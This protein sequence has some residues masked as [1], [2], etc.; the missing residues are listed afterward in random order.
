MTAT[1]RRFLAL[2]PLAA[3]LSFVACVSPDAPPHGAEGEVSRELRAPL[4]RCWRETVAAIHELGVPVPQDQRPDVHRGE[5]RTEEV[6]VDLLWL[7][8][9][10]RTEARVLFHDR[11]P[12]RA[13]VRGESLLDAIE[14]RLTR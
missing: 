14:V 10:E 13:R 12:L 6:R 1:R 9:G 7:E 2:F 8:G 11:D 4:E 5:I 3:A